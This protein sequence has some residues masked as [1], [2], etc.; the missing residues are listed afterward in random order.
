MTRGGN[1]LYL[2]QSVN[3]IYSLKKIQD[4][5]EFVVPQQLKGF[6]CPT[7]VRSLGIANGKRQACVSQVGKYKSAISIT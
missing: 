4:T 6:G 7:L 2:V 3:F 1:D 5:L